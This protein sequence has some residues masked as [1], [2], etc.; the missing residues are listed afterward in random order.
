MLYFLLNVAV[1]LYVLLQSKNKV[2]LRNLSM[3]M[4]QLEG[5]P[6]ERQALIKE[7]VERAKD[8]VQLDLADG[9]SWCEFSESDV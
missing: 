6:E 5:N 1:A 2:S 9:T 8:A 4:R 7:S 3:V